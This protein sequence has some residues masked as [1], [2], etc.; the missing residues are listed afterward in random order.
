[1]AESFSV[2]NTPR[3][4]TARRGLP[5]GVF[6]WLAVGVA[7]LFSAVVFHERD[8]AWLATAPLGMALFLWL[9][10]EP[11]FEL[12]LGETSLA[13]NA[14]LP[15]A[16]ES[17]T[18]V[19][20]LNDIA[21][22]PEAFSI[23]VR[24]AAGQTLIPAALD[25]P[26]KELFAWLQRQAPPYVLQVNP[27]LNEYLTAQE[28]L[29]GNRIAI[30]V[31]ETRSS[32]HNHRRLVKAILATALVCAIAGIAAYASGAGQDGSLVLGIIATAIFIVI[33]LFT[34]LALSRAQPLNYEAAGLIITPA[35]LAMVQGDLA[36]ELRWE[37]IRSAKL[38]S[39]TV[40]VARNQ[41]VRGPCIHLSVQGATIQIADIYHEPVS[42]IYAAIQ[43]L[44]TV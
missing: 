39:G 19:R 30:F 6:A 31:G 12:H 17:I 28:A 9:F 15:I 10:R 33:G 2:V 43:R 34:L 13:V 42:Q 11:R 26:S 16:Y 41:Q 44:R 3:R 7:T 27:R 20:P 23:L 8:L 40:A 36:G 38:S 22:T 1:M 21:Q 24:H 4:V 25:I 37:E 35:G 14:G 29:Y 32:E 5:L 18:R